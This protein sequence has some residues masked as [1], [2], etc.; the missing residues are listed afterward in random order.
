VA[1]SQRRV[2]SRCTGPHDRRTCAARYRLDFIAD[3]QRSAPFRASIPIHDAPIATDGS[4]SRRSARANRHSSR[5]ETHAD[6][7]ARIR[8]ST[9]VRATSSD[10]SGFT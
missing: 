9:T 1:V 5:N 10:H 7:S 3:E 2:A 4:T 6:G 8:K